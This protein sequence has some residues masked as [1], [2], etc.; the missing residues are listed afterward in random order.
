LGNALPEVVV[1]DFNADQDDPPC[2]HPLCIATGLT[3]PYD[4]LSNPAMFWLP[5]AP[6]TDVW[7]LRHN[8]RSAAG[9]TCCFLSLSAP[10][11]ADINRRVD[12]I[13][14]RGAVASGTTVRLQG[15][16][17]RHLTDSGLFASDHLGVMAR[18]TLMPGP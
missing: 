14:T 12:L 13:W 6:M 15:D 8:D 1:G 11:P 18:T 9:G 4:I 3:N 7:T 2:S 17:D 5:I 10:D 16:D